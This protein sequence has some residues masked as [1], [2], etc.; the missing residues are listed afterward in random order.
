MLDYDVDPI[1]TAA[2]S[3]S[4]LA[5]KV[6]H[7]LAVQQCVSS[8]FVRNIL[9]CSSVLSKTHTKQPE[10]LYNACIPRL[11][12]ICTRSNACVTLCPGFSLSKGLA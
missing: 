4:K 7:S 5:V 11:S 12:C 3:K 8:E 6:L 1:Y 2:A 10:W 9:A